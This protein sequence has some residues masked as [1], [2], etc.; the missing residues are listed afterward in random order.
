[1]LRI[2]T[3]S[4]VAKQEEHEFVKSEMSLDLIHKKFFY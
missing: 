3:E 1:M 2:Q 4:H